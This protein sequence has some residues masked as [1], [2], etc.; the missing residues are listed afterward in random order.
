[1]V[2]TISSKP[3]H[4]TAAQQ[5]A[6]KATCDTPVLVSTQAADPFKV[7]PN[8]KIAK[9][10]F[11]TAK[12]IMDVYLG[13]SFHTTITNF[14][15]V[16]VHIPKHQKILEVA[17]A[18]IKIF[19]IMIEHFSYPSGADATSNDMSINTV[20]YIPTPDR[21]D[22]MKDHETVKKEDKKISN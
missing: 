6:L 17:D 1:M 19:H 22:L 7:I 9:H 15:R 18:L 2:A 4:I 14:E 20:Q 3:R 8:E 21:L 12:G 16:D 5:V 10:A 13:R 11:T